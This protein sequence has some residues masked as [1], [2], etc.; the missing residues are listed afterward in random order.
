M[1][2]NKDFFFPPEV[3]KKGRQ[4][5]VDW[6][7]PCSTCRQWTRA[8]VVGTVLFIIPPGLIAVS[9]TVMLTVNHFPNSSWGHL[10]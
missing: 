7:L 9:H 6:T 8:G 4:V 10:S 1:Y 3:I 5:G 2:G